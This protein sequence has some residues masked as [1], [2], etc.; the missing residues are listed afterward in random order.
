MALLTIHTYPDPVLKEQAKPVTE[1]DSRVR[2]L[3]DDM[4]ETMY[5]APGI[6]LAANQVGKLEQII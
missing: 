4:A 5:D 2:K 6:G 1:I 3:I